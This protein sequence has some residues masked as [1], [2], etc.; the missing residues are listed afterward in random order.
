MSSSNRRLAVVLAYL[1][2]GAAL[3]FPLFAVVRLLRASFP[4]PRIFCVPPC[5]LSRHVFCPIEVPAIARPLGRRRGAVARV[6]P[7]PGVRSNR[8]G[9]GR[10][11]PRGIRSLAVGVTP[12]DAW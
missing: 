2:I 11:T 7:A 9:D 12:A 1:V 10:L 8:G 3:R 4:S 5:G 6:G